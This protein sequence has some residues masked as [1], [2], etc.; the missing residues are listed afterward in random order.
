MRRLVLEE[1]GEA[2]HL[3]GIEV[4]KVTPVFLEAMC[5]GQSGGVVTQVVFAEL[6][7]VIAKIEQELCECGCAG[8]QVGGA[9]RQLRR[10]H[11]GA[12]GETPPQEDRS[13]GPCAL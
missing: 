7:G 3:H 2:Y 5:R 6:T 10:E 8:V 13:A 4:V 9:A 12:Q 11:C 1:I